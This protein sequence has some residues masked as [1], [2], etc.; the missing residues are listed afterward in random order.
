M[1]DRRYKIFLAIWMEIDYNVWAIMFRFQLTLSLWL[2][3]G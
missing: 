1:E 2:S 3:V